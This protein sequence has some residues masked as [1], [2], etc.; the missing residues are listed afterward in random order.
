MLCFTAGARDRPSACDALRGRLAASRLL[1][2][3]VVRACPGSERTADPQAD[4]ERGGQ[5][6]FHAVG[7]QVHLPGQAERESRHRHPTDALSN[8]FQKWRRDRD[9]EYQWRN[10]LRNLPAARCHRCQDYHRRRGTLPDIARRRPQTSLGAGRRLKFLAIQAEPNGSPIP[11]YGQCP[12]G[13]TI[14][15]ELALKLRTKQLIAA[16]RCGPRGRWQPRAKL[17]WR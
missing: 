3:T 1:H 5:G 10:G 15:P 7:E 4:N 9:S 6:M 14:P 12:S 11:V 8:Q 2:G 17:I 13:P 16:Q